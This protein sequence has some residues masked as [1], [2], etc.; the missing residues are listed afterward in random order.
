MEDAKP[1]ILYVDDE[2]QN[3]V[4]FKASFRRYYDVLTAQSGEEALE[5]LRSEPVALIIS[6][7][8]MPQMTGVEF[9][10]KVLLSFPDPIRMVMTGYSDMEAIVQAVN[11][12]KIY[13]YI[14]KPWKQQELKL[15]IDNGLEAFRL[16]TENRGLQEEKSALLLKAARQEKENILSRFE[17]LRNQV[18]PHFLFNCLNALSTLVHDDPDLAETFI[19]RLTRVYRYV[20]DFREENLVPLEDELNVLKNYFFLQQIRFGNNLRMYSQVSEALWSCLVPP[21]TLQMLVE[22]SI[23]HNIISGEQPLTIELYTE[24]DRFFVVK[25]NYQKR[26]GNV[27]STGVG[28]EN[29]IARYA[30]FTSEKPSFGVE[31]GYYY[32]RVPILRP[33]EVK[34]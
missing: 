23:K 24:E 3:L 7:Q 15:I 12:G 29:L 33:G 5:L 11:K 19:A 26:T 6:D 22:N 10:E 30:F 9:L 18:N 32:A 13:Y 34:E 2:Y 28:L 14:T 27:E 17:T 1:A 4:S 25:N 20:L 31:N 21:M 8:R 16:K